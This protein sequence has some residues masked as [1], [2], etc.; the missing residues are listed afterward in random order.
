MP[1]AIVLRRAEVPTEPKVPKTNQDFCIGCGVCVKVCP[2]EGVI[3]LVKEP[4]LDGVFAMTSDTP[5][6][7]IGVTV[8]LAP[9]ETCTLPEFCVRCRKCVEECPTNARAF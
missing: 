1:E 4:V 3:L 8:A 5:L 9:F 7:K 6:S 2:V